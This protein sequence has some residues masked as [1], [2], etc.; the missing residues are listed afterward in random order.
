MLKF[1]ASAAAALMISTAA[2]AASFEEFWPEIWAQLP[3][4]LRADVGAMDFKQGEILLKDGIAAVSIPDTYYYLNPADSQIM[5]EKMWGNP[6]GMPPLGIIMPRDLTP[7]H[8]DAW[9]AIL[10]FDPVGYV[11]DKD[12]ASTDFNAVLEQSKADAIAQSEERV[13]LG[14]DPVYLMGWA[15]APHYDGESRT[16][17]W[18]KDLVF[19]T[20]ELHSLNY[21]ARIL[22]RKGVLQMNFVA[23]MDQLAEVKQKAPEVMQM[24][25]FTRGHSYLDF[26]PSVDKVAAYGI[27]GLIAAKV[28]AKVGFLGVALL[29]LKK[30]FFLLFIP[31]VWLKNKIFRRPE[32]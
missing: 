24:A 9:A 25:T 32:A 6:K 20:N 31:L 16:L 8:P 12:A 26:D 13:K 1:L 11:E 29:F 3:G 27:G 17:Y 10:D 7:I 22:G 21:N 4:D 2:N 23:G 5:L 18:A 30:F 14:M 19:G 15:E 28:A